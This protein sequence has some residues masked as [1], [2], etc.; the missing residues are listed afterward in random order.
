MAQVAPHRSKVQVD[1]LLYVLDE[2]GDHNIG[3]ECWHFKDFKIYLY[4][5][6]I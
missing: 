3:K 5:K 2:D 4:F 6:I 1:L